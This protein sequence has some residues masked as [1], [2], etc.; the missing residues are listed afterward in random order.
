MNTN[1]KSLDRMQEI[2]RNDFKESWLRK[3]KLIQI[4]E[5]MNMNDKQYN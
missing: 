4:I 2:E 5:L 1:L 3:K